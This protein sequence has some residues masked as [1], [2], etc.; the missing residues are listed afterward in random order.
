MQCFTDTFFAGV[1]SL[2]VN[3]C[4]RIFTDGEYI[5]IY[6]MKSKKEDENGPKNFTEYVGIPDVIM[7]DNYGE[8]N[9]SQH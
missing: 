8:K 7:R 2:M 6:P 1:K 9:W 3:I 5:Y 4:A